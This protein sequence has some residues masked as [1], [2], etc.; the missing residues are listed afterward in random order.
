MNV[1]D[2]DGD[3]KHEIVF[4]VADANAYGYHIYEWDGVVGSDNYGT[5]FSSVNNVEVGICCPDGAVFRGRTEQ[6]EIDD[7]DGD[8]QNE[9]IVAIRD[10]LNRGLLIT[11][12]AAGDDIVHNSGGGFETWSQ[13]FKTENTEYGGGSPYH[14]LPVDLNGDGQKEIVNHHWNNFNFFS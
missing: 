2:L 7:V 14:A 6:F 9:L 12:L 1:G 10:G 13:E 3:G 8:G 4:P 11:T 5:T